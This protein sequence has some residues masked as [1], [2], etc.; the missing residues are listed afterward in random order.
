[1]R[2][3]INLIYYWA[4]LFFALIYLKYNLQTEQIFSIINNTLIF[5]ANKM[6]NKYKNV[7]I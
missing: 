7:C 5:L 3:K 2:L 6:N 1:M 4:F